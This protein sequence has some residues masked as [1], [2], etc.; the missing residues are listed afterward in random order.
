MGVGWGRMSARFYALLSDMIL[1]VHTGFVAFIVLGFVVIW[2]GYFGGWK[3]VRNFRFR[4]AH[5]LAMGFVAAESLVGMVCPLTTWE[6]ELRRRAGEGS[7]YQ[8]SFVEHWLGQIL[9][10][11]LS[12]QAFTLIYSAFFVLVIATF[13][14]VPPRRRRRRTE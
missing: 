1:V 5:L 8:E 14:L 12:D 9:Y 4:M 11:E 3:F 2:F 7:A 6:N 10:Y 13:V